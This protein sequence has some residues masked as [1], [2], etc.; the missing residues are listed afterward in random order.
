MPRTRTAAPHNALYATRREAMMLASMQATH[1]ACS[2]AR[3]GCTRAALRGLG[4]TRAC[5]RPCAAETCVPAARRRT[6]SVRDRPMAV[7]AAGW[8]PRAGQCM[9]RRAWRSQTHQSHWYRPHTRTR[10]IVGA[11]PA[12][13]PAPAVSSEYRLVEWLAYGYRGKTGIAAGRVLR[14]TAER[15]GCGR[16]AARSGCAARA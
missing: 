15:L 14:S 5:A 12:S 2:A 10:S 16:H 13:V 11:S 8:C 4:C 9:R 1:T 3:A 7:P 6:K